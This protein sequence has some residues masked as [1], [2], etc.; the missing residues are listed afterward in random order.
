MA[1]LRVK[2]VAACVYRNANAKVCKIIIKY[3]A[4]FRK[5]PISIPCIYGHLMF[6]FFFFVCVCVTVLGSAHSRL[7]VPGHE[8]LWNYLPV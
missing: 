3:M 6:F 1:A 5:F 8:R 2:H 4:P 7:S